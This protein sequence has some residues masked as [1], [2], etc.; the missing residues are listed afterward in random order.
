MNQTGP[1]PIS[2]C[3]IVY[4]AA[5][6]SWLL[7]WPVSRVC[8]YPNL[9]PPTMSA[10]CKKYR[11]RS[12]AWSAIRK[13]CQRVLLGP[14][15]SYAQEKP[16]RGMQWLWVAAASLVALELHRHRFKSHA[17]PTIVDWFLCWLYVLDT[18]IGRS[19]NIYKV[20]VALSLERSKPLSKRV[21][22]RVRSELGHRN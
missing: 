11:Q 5:G 3:N 14:E 18:S 10:I 9:V 7:D 22:T 1:K 19:P 21:K 15:T 13:M 6:S 12:L 4:K 8:S 2:L 17:T 20:G 16:C